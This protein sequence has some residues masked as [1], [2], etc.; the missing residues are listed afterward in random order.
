MT[1][2]LN[3]HTD[4]RHLWGRYIDFLWLRG[5][6]CLQSAGLPSDICPQNI[7][8]SFYK[9]HEGEELVVLP[10]QVNASVSEG[11][12]VVWNR[13]DLGN[14]IVHARQQDGGDLKN[15]IER[16]TNRTSMRTD[17]LQTGD[18]SLTLGKPSISDSGNYTCT[19][20]RSGQDLSQIQVQLTV[21]GQCCRYRAEVR[22]HSRKILLL[23]NLFLK[24]NI[25]LLSTAESS[26]FLYKVL[27]GILV[28]LF[29]LLAVGV[30]VWYICK[31]KKKARQGMCSVCLRTR[32]RSSQTV[33]TGAMCGS[34]SF[35]G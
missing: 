29:L 17:A 26:T 2:G 4:S 8:W 33:P 13:K 1:T 25:M 21:T 31:R 27:A 3:T 6:C 12:T 10:C 15:Q 20:R 11:S 24:C 7:Y 30:T 9:V 32:A 28:P 5:H 19:V 34:I 35:E 14:D 22:G 18:L 16:Y 23:I